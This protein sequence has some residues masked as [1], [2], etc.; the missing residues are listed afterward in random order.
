MHP[1][2]SLYY[3]ITGKPLFD[4]ATMSHSQTVGNKINPRYYMK[5]ATANLT[6]WQLLFHVPR[7]LNL[8]NGHPPILTL[9][10]NL[11]YRI[12]VANTMPDRKH[13]PH[14]H[15]YITQCLDMHA[16]RCLSI[17]TT[18]RH[19]YTRLQAPVGLGA[20]TDVHWRMV[21]FFYCMQPYKMIKGTMPFFICS[22]H[23]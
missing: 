22:A 8:S 23:M 19:T 16:N 4:I 21:F 14:L 17:H 20:N 2:Y 3:N 7:Y 6:I 13:Q 15:T 12:T 10:S 18:H 11:L 1:L 5:N 9:L